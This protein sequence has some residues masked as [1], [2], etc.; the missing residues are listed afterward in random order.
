M[1]TDVAHNVGRFLSVCRRG[2][3]TDHPR[4]RIIERDISFMMRCF[5][6]AAAVWPWC[7]IGHWDVVGHGVMSSYEIMEGP[8]TRI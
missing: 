2:R 6:L 3:L 5:R 7:W 1:A 8:L 4:H